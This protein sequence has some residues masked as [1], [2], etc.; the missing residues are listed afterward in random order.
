MFEDNDKVHV[1]DSMLAVGGMR[2]IVE[3]INKYRDQSI[4]T[5]LEKVDALI[6]RIRVLAI[7]ETLDY[8]FKGGRLSKLEWLVGSLL[9]IK[10][11]ITF[12]DGNVKVDAK[13]IGL[14]NSMKYIAGELNREADPS[15]H[16]IPSY[17]YKDN[18]L[19]KLIAL[20]NKSLYRSM[21]EFDN[22]DPVIA[23]HWGPNAFGFIYVKKEN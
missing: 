16:I 3:E 19:K 6:P 10:P 22:L 20:T 11:I 4:Q 21:T 18:N 1:I 8:L 15:Y 12:V 5:I 14:A 23:C 9:N 17:T 7:P 13:K 2:L